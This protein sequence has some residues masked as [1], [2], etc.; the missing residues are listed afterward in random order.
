MKKIHAF[1]SF[2]YS[3]LNRARVLAKSLRRHHPDWVI[4]AVIT[5]L[6]PPGF[7]FDLSKENFDR[8]LTAETLF[9]EITNRWLF[10]HDIVEACTAV[11]GRALQYIMADPTAEKVVYFDPDI[12]VFNHMNDV[13]ELLNEYSIVLTPH[14]I[15]PE[16]AT[17]H[18]AIRDNEITSL[19]YGVFNLGFIAVNQSMEAHRFAQWWA[20]RLFDWCHDRLDIG[21]FVDQKW[22]NLI[23]CFFDS[24]KV[25][26][27][28]GYN[29]ASWNLSQR[30]M[31][32]D[33]FG[34]AQINGKPLRFYH[35]TK[36]GPIGDTMTRRYAGLNTEIY[37]L[38]WWYRQ[39]VISATDPSI[40]KGWWHYGIFDNNFPIDKQTRTTYRDRKDLQMKF[41][42]PF[43]T[44]PGTFFN[45]LE[46]Q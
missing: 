3:Y 14:Q 30:T 24:I 7:E 16:P 9:G 13:I 39:E 4:W 28:P 34:Q 6:P 32:Y 25:L 20:D 8:I 36:L 29:V 26:R 10:K 46:L 42:E 2:S 11:K 40:P 21:V 18:H 44:G 12:A 33:A 23:P 37:E 45:W 1:T 27:D 35:F 19:D 17:H 22:C 38:W 5:D 43:K 15:D 31:S 41:T